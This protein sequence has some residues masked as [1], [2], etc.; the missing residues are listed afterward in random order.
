[1]SGIRTGFTIRK[2]GARWRAAL[3]ASAATVS[4]ATHGTAGAQE[5]PDRVQALE[6]QLR[7]VLATVEALS[8][9]LRE[10]KTAPPPA[11]AAAPGGI[12]GIALSERLDQV[13][14]SVERTNARLAD[15]EEIALD[16]DERV[17]SRALVRAFDAESF[18]LGGFF[19]TAATLVDG[20][21]N[22]EVAVNRMTFELLARAR[23]NDDW[24]LF[25]A[26]AFIRE[27]DLN[28]A[29]PTNRLDPN[30]RVETRTPLVIATATW[31]PNNA[32]ELDLGRFL[33]PHGIVNIEHF[34]ATLLDPEQPQFLR[35]FGAQT[36]F[37]NFMN[38]AK[39]GG[40]VFNPGGLAGEFG[41]TAYVGS[42]VNNSDSFNYGGRVHY[43]FGDSGLTGG[44]NAGGGRR[45]GEDSDY[46]LFGADLLY[47]KGP[48]LWKNEVYITDEDV[49]DD[50][51]AFYSQPAWRIDDRWTAFYRFDFLDDGTPEGD[52]IE[53]SFGINFNPHKNVRLR[54]IARLNRFERVPATPEHPEFPD[55]NLEAYQL[56]ATFSF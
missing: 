5:N 15:V 18:D 17:G 40:K 20:R 36:I 6:E 41:Y 28:F 22:T 35:P 12:S 46:V 49:G 24:S 43:K 2:D 45:E 1:M 3:L 29:D 33:T 31:K 26:Q 9:E 13:A 42:F 8:A 51:L 32:F 21:D 16:V 11:A 14:A 38:G 52:K 23:I 10:L 7:A 30:F 19:H 4:L 27:S 56:S 39:V 25:A 50:R 54:A 47:D 34:P 44:L 53:H 48:I 37:A 55:A